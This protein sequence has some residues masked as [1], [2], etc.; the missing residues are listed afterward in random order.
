MLRAQIKGRLLLRDAEKSLP[1]GRHLAIVQTIILKAHSFHRTRN[2]AP[3]TPSG[4]PTIKDGGRLAFPSRV[5]WLPINHP[6][7]N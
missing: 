1:E 2:L 6:L 3:G 5:R 4:T 7:I